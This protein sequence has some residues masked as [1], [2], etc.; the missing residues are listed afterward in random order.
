MEIRDVIIAAVIW[1]ELFC[2][3]EIMDHMDMVKFQAAA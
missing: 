3:G 2:R 1:G